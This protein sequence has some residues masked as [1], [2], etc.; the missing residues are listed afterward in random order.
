MQGPGRQVTK[1]DVDAIVQDHF[2][3]DPSNPIICL[4]QVL[5]NSI[6]ISFSTTQPTTK[7]HLT[8]LPNYSCT[9]FLAD[10]ADTLAGLPPCAVIDLQDTWMPEIL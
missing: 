3:I 7:K 4:T 9:V 8:I 2:N 10:M 1:A 5:L 6:L